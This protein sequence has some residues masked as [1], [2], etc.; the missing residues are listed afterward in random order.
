[1]NVVVH[2]RGSPRPGMAVAI[3][4][5][6]LAGRLLFMLP[7]CFAPIFGQGADGSPPALVL[8]N[9]YREG[10]DVSR[11]WVSEK[12]DGA[13]AYWD[14][15]ALYFRSGR[16]VRAPA[17]F[18][19]AFP[20]Q[21]LDGELWTGR[22]EFDRLSGIIRKEVPLDAE[23][24]AVR[25]M[26]FELPEARGD[27]TTRLTRLREIVEGA[28]VPWLRM[29]EQER[30]ADHGALRRRLEAVVKAGGEGLMLHLADA[31]YVSGRND[32]L[33]KLKPWLDAEAIVTAQIPGKGKYAG[34]LGALRVERPDGRRF[35]LGTGFS[36]AQRRDPPSVGTL[37]TY[38]YRELNKNGLP[39]FASFL[40]VRQNF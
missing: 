15:K 40:R 37:V 7:L 28:G 22:G 13:R 33:L 23:W 9:I 31:P 6:R 38:R 8:A 27:F 10:I 3:Q 18:T 24:R 1:M 12:L 39:R 4:P 34:M 19:A 30:M 14:G 11:Y 21:A 2:P 17:W 16:P 29:V 25:Y 26:V 32:A 36:D 35:N 20:A 5:W